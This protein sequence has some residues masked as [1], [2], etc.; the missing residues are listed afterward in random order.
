MLASLCHLESLGP[1]SGH[2]P[3]PASHPTGVSSFSSWRNK[4]VPAL[5]PRQPR[6]IQ[7]QHGQAADASRE[8]EGRL[9]S[10]K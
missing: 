5:R 4:A 8:E 3:D 10:T 7:D 1:P 6:A 2:L 9:F